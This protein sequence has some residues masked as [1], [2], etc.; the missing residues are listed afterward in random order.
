MKKTPVNMDLEPGTYYWCSCGKSKK[1]PFCDGSHKDTKK[2]PLEFKIKEKKQVAICS[3][4][5][6]KT[7]PFCDG[8]HLKA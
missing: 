8:S 5:K 3:C 4:Q 1:L 6:T 7:P 2:V